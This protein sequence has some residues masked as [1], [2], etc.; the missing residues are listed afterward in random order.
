MQNTFQHGDLN[1]QRHLIFPPE[2][3]KNLRRVL[4]LSENTFL[5]ISDD[6][7]PINPIPT[8][9]GRNQPIYERHVTKS[10]RNRVNKKNRSNEIIWPKKCIS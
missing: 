3:S 9:Q 8:G 4:L 5:K 6:I 1:R 10:G 2:F 7:L